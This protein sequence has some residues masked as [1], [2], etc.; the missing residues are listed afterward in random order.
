MFLY[1]T[2][3]YKNMFIVVEIMCKIFSETGKLVKKS[4]FTPRKPFQSEGGK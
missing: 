1:E 4:P 3:K 2:Q